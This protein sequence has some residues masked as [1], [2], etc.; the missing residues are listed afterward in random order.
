MPAIYLLI[1]PASG[2][3]NLRCRYCFYA[4]EMENR[5]FPSRGKM[6]PAVMRAM[7]DRAW[8]YA[9]GAVTFAFQGGEPTLAGLPYYRDFLSYV[10]TRQ[11]E[12][13][14]KVQYILQTNGTLLNEAWADLFAAHHFLIG[15]SLDGTKELHDRY[16][17]DPQG[18][19]T[20]NRVM[21]A[22]R[23]LEKKGVT[24]NILTVVTGQMA[25]SAG[26]VWNFFQ[27][28]HFAYQQYIECLDPIGEEPGKRA[29]SL[30]PARYGE[31]LKTSFDCWYQEIKAGHFAY[32]RY[33][34]NLLLI[35]SGQ[36]PESCSMQGVCG[37]QWVIEADGSVYPCDF[38]ALDAW[39]LGNVTEETFAEM[40]ERREKLA[41]VEVSREV[42]EACRV[43]RWYRLCR[44]GC[45]RLRETGAEGRYGCNYF[46]SAYREFFEYA[47]PRLE[48]L[49]RM[50]L[51]QK[52]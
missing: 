23:L 30:T 22:I 52:Q 40:A 13:R 21:T 14:L 47:Y 8:E 9:D 10:Q 27:K 28:N 46:C 41:F 32:N 5:S 26:K 16:R 51:L 43:C 25:H 15:I 20:Y 17:V 37:R 44:N 31:F 42:P 7:I 45:R 35:L 19:G 39:R 2:N 1:K 34:E 49:Y 38:Y 4:D 6:E 18:K 12:K 11:R 33:F 50:L 48:E 3:C 36:S 24:Y 29:Y